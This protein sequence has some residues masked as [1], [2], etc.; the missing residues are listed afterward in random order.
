M[1]QLKRQQ[2]LRTDPDTCWK[3]FSS[4]QNLAVITPE[5]MRFTVLTEQPDSVYEGLI[6]AYTVSPVLGIPLKWVTEIK[7]VKENLFFVDEQRKGPYS[8]WHHEHHFEQ[9]ENGVLMTDIVSYSLPYGWIGR[10]AHRLFVKKQL[11]AVFDYRR[12]IVDEMFNAD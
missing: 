10:L 1:Y 5:Y 7:Y 2:L 11:E 4:P 8:F 3:F 9:V 6:I 12:K